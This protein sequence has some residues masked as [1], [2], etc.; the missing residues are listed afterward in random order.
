MKRREFLKISTLLGTGGALPP[1]MLGGCAE[2]PLPGDG[3]V[4]S[5][6]TIC[7]I[8]F[9][10]CAGR[11]YVEDGRPWKIIG[12]PDD[13]H[14]RGRLCTRGTGGLGAYQDPDRLK[15]PLLRVTGKGRQRFEAVSWDD[16]LDFVAGRMQKI[17]NEH[18]PDRVALFSHGSGGTFFKH[19]LRA[20][21][22]GS[23]AAPSF[24]QCRGPRDVAFQLTYGEGVGSPDRTDMA[25]SRC[26][27][28]IGSHIGENLHNGQVQTFTEALD[29]GAT[30]ITVDPRFSVAAGKSRYW[31]PIK[32]GTDIALLLAWMNILIREELYNRDYV[33][34]YATGFDELAAHV[35][36]YTPEWA[37]LET[38]LKPELI[39]KTARE[40]AR[41]APA[42]LLHPG[43]HTT[44]YGD[45][46][47]RGR[48][49]AIVN[50]LLGSWGSRGGYYYPEKVELPKYPYPAYPKPRSTFRDANRGRF[51]FANLGVSNAMIDES[52]GPDA[53][54]KGWLVYGT[55][56]PMTIPGIRGKLAA[57]MNALD[58]VAVIDTMPME[59]TGYAD[60]VLPECTYLE[61][62]DELRNSPEMAPSLAL[63]MPAFE[64]RHETKPG[65]WIARELGLKLGLD[66]YFP[67]K[68][69]TEVLDWQLKQ[70]GSSLEEMQQTG[71]KPFP[72]KTEPYFRP[73]EERKF[74]TPS[75][76]IELYSKQLEQAGFDPMPVYSAPQQP[77][78]GY[79]RL[80]YG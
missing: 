50:A 51:P 78:Q 76:R 65:W 80:N 73:G 27:V 8:C 17:A 66:D 28:L 72:R 3:E 39:R 35:A 42:T 61:R 20:Y 64:P 25:N 33:A 41:H 31:L 24:A 57:A 79:Y 74:R 59:I 22:S 70:V 47:Q 34:R 46:T 56:L 18:G 26:I 19:L 14:G 69:F 71:L 38:G 55:N 5:T 40:M 77:P 32:P 2:R 30:L 11:V 36:P 58:L 16:A 62:Y 44:W 12:H 68:D 37:W 49:I 10:K 13:L 45:D 63:R 75:G 54:Y 23:I 9:W 21:G 1:L 7:D 4:V 52:L 29:K 6:P 15:R 67:W 60:I 43:R 53:H 48:A